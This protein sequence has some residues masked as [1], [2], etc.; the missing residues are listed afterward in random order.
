M[1]MTVLR[2]NAYRTNETLPSVV[3]FTR[4]IL[5]A[6][7]ITAVREHASTYWEKHTKNGEDALLEHLRDVMASMPADDILDLHYTYQQGNT[8]QMAGMFMEKMTS[9]G[10]LKKQID[11]V[12]E[13][14]LDHLGFFY[15]KF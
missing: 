9:M 11:D 6:P 2:E 1:E 13:T 3:G 8:R 14:T 10:E 12:C 15:E 4:L 5:T 7:V